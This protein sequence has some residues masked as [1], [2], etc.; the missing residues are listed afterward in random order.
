MEHDGVEG[1]SLWDWLA[2]EVHGPVDPEQGSQGEDLAPGSDGSFFGDVGQFV[3]DIGR[4]LS[5][6][7]IGGLLD[8]FGMMDRQDA[9]RDL[10]SR[11]N[12]MP[13]GAVGTR[14]QNQVS[15]EEFEE[16]ARD[17]SDIR[18]G[19]SDL[20]LAGQGTMTDE[21]Y[22]SF[23]ENTMGD[24]ADI[25]QTESGRGLVDSMSDAPL[26][27]D[28]TSRR[29]TTI[30]PRFNAAGALDPS[31]A[32]GGGTFGQSGQVTY[33]PGVDTAPSGTNLRSDVTLYHE[34]THA[35]HAV[36]N[37][38]DAGSVAGTRSA[39][40]PDGGLGQFEHQA[41]GLGDYA[42]AE[43]SENR[44]RGERRRIG[45][46]NVGERNHGSQSDDNMM[47]RDQYRTPLDASGNVVPQST[48]APLLP[49]P[50]IW[51]ML[52]GSGSG[53]GSGGGVGDAS[54]VGQSTDEEHPHHH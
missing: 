21:E 5:Q 33:V 47:R 27:A 13:E 18:M 9:Q 45:E 49:E 4:G 24:I 11:F 53:S 38:W 48:P 43:F 42:D 26:Q 25:M 36:Y 51:N 16:I 8:P 54:R 32:T 22:A 52:F 39:A 46:L 28:G 14:E 2:D 15:Q 50:S 44:Y 7:G 41:A 30:N 12:V 31:N 29:T 34:L 37:T 20:Q 1:D 10:A 17:Y 40:N 6:E 35:H 19:R 3:G 23:R